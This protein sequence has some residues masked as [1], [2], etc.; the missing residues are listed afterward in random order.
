VIVQGQ[1]QALVL[2]ERD[3]LHMRHMVVVVVELHMMV[4]EP[5]THDVPRQALGVDE[6]EKDL[7]NQCVYNLHQFAFVYSDHRHWN[8]QQ[9]PF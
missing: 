3:N 1:E 5:C 7:N 4:V 8:Q 6:K 2:E 9:S